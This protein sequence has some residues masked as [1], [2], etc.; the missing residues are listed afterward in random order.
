MVRSE[1]KRER[2]WHYFNSAVQKRL[3]AEMKVDS[4]LSSFGFDRSEGMS[5][6]PRIP[7]A[8][9]AI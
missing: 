7:A 8:N 2:D 4:G 1:V 6:L 5:T 9:Q 3:V